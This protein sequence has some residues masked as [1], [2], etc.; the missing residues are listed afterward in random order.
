[1]KIQKSFLIIIL[2]LCALGC[3]SDDK[4]EI[5]SIE[6]TEWVSLE[7]GT[8]GDATE[9]ASGKQIGTYFRVA[10]SGI[11][12]FQ[13][14]SKNNSRK[15]SG[16]YK[17]DYPNF[18]IEMDNGAMAKYSV[19]KEYMTLV[20]GDNSY[21][22][23]FFPEKV[24]LCTEGKSTYKETAI[25]ILTG[26][27]WYMTYIAVEGQN[28]MYDFWQG[29]QEA[30]EKSFKT[31]VGDN[32]TLVFDGTEVNGTA[33]GACV[34]KAISVFAH[35]EWSANGNSR[36]LKI[37]LKNTGTDTDKY[38]GKAF[39]DGLKSAFKYGGDSKNLYIY[40]KEGETVKFISFAPQR[41][42]SN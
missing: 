19:T 16:I 10:L 36:E 30:R 39:M 9:I 26:K 7:N 17:Y 4:D 34:G 21:N 35:G 29:D 1:M 27:T 15:Y 5:T 37:T 14:M 22:G 18:I 40:Y 23:I 28:K 11:E 32:Y 42:S 24:Y 2:I 3:S 38:L 12:I 33:G 6:G 20:G 8:T 25:D 31:I 41:N 13:T